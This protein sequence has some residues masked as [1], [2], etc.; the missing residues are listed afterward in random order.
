MSH[1]EFL[2]NAPADVL[3]GHIAAPRALTLVFHSDPGHGWLEVPV[4]HLRELGIAGEISGYS[5]LRHGP[6]HGSA[7]L[8]ED[9][10]APCFL[11]AARAAGWDVTTRDNYLRSTANPLRALPRYDAAAVAAGV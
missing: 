1:T 2:P 8:E 4:A 5:Y 10:D 11:R 3:A 9:C 6:R 7:F